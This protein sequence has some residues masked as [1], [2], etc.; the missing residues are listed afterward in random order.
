M[1]SVT[2]KILQKENKRLKKE[3][4]KLKDELEHLWADRN[5]AYKEITRLKK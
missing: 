3:N 1:H 4:E 2:V 5:N